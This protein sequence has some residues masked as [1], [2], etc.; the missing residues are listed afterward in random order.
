M[1]TSG[2][3]RNGNANGNGN[4]QVVSLRPPFL[5][6]RGLFWLSLVL[7]P[8]SF[9]S[10]QSGQV[11]SYPNTASNKNA[12]Q[13]DPTIPLRPTFHQ[14]PTLNVALLA[15]SARVS[16]ALAASRQSKARPP[17]APPPPERV[18]SV[19]PTKTNANRNT[20]YNSK[21]WSPHNTTPLQVLQMTA[22]DPAADMTSR[23]AAPQFARPCMYFCMFF[24]FFLCPRNR[25]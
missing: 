22:R 21:S 14:P 3:N 11:G 10:S 23:D 8:C 18:H 13:P 24:L 12:F 25:T 17:G 4:G 6:N 1:S 5:S 20:E 9:H 19:R 16:G 15:P 7:V 2:G